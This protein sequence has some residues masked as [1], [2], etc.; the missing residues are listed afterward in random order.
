VPADADL[1]IDT[2]EYSAEAAADLIIDRL[3]GDG[4]LAADSRG[5]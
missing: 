5:R 3:R 4:Y 1:S 2:G